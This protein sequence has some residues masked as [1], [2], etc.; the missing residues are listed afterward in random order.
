MAQLVTGATLEPG[1]V[2]GSG[3]DLVESFQREW[4]PP[5]SVAA[6]M[7]QVLEH[8]RRRDLHRIPRHDGDEHLEIERHG[9][10]CVRPA[11]ASDELEIAVDEG[12]AERVAD[13]PPNGETDRTKTGQQLI[14][15]PSHR[16][17]NP[18]RMPPRSPEY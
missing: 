11:S 9:P 18:P 16:P 6:L 5:P 7:G 4:P 2:L 12:I 15:R 17:E 1:A 13:L 14:G 10:Q 8:V 3:D